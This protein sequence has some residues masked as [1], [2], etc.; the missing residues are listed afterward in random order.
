MS[1]RIA[2][3]I[4]LIVAIAIFGFFYLIRSCL[5]KYDERAAIGG[6]SNAQSASQFLVFENEG[7][8]VIF[9]VIKY[10]KTI[11]YSKKGG[12]TSR[13]VSTTYYLQTNNGETAEKLALEKLKSHKEIQSYPVE[14]MGAAAG[15]A[16]LF[17]G[18]LMAFDPF[19]LKKQLDATIIEQNNPDLKGRLLNERR[20]YQFDAANNGI[21]LTTSDGLKYLLNTA[22]LKATLKEEE[23]DT[24]EKV[25]D[26]LGKKIMKIREQRTKAYERLRKNNK[27]Y[28]DGTLPLKEYKD[29]A[30]AIEAQ[31]KVLTTEM[32][33]L[34]KQQR[35]VRDGQWDAQIKERKKMQRIGGNSY[36][37][38]KVNNDTV[39]GKWYGLYTL[40]KLRNIS[41]R[42]DYDNVFEPAARNKLYVAS[43]TPKEQYWE[44]SDEKEKA[45]EAVYLQGGFLMN[46]KTAMPVRFDNG[47]LIVHKNSIDKNGVALLT[48]INWQSQP[49]WTVNTGV[50]EFEEWEISH[51]HLIITGRDNKELSGGEANLLLI[52]DLKTGKKVAYD[53][54]TDKVRKME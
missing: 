7:K 28:S 51:N 29:S 12:M 27:L 37:G 25:I 54:F 16:W 17:A 20:Y 50:E 3:R 5:S 35:I 31:I 48:R 40:E 43:L 52:I 34:N 11:S 23:E 13:S 6:G 24:V 4:V 30:A 8:S 32:D 19:T 42:F 49:L 1:K 9:S 18:E 47:F 53:Y 14:I 10:D 22:T 2:L 39:N 36:N 26:G 33:S 38:M 44:I 21:E 46:K 45:G 15:R 41:T